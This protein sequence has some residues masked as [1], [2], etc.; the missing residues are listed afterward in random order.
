MCPNY[1][2]ADYVVIVRPLWRRLR[3]G[4]DVVARHPVF[5][6]IFKRVDS[7]RGEQLRLKGLDVRSTSS[8]EIGWVACADVLGRVVL[9][10][11]A[12]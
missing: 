5:G 7:L 1:N 11:R 4:D 8:A 2:A 3:A 6:T 12:P 9:H 10:I